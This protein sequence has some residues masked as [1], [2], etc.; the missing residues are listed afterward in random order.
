MTCHPCR[1]LFRSFLL[2]AGLLLLPVSLSLGDDL[3]PSQTLIEWDAKWRY[4]DGNQDL[5]EGWRAPDYD[6]GGWKEGPALLGYSRSSENPNWPPPGLQTRMAPGLGTYY[7]RTEFDFTGTTEHMKLR[8]DHIVDDAAVFYLNGKEIGRSRFAPEG[9]VTFSSR[10]AGKSDPA[11]ESAIFPLDAATLRQGRNVLAVSLHNRDTSSSDIAFAARLVAEDRRVEGPPVG[12]VLTWQRDPTT[13]MTVDWHRRPTELASP[14]KIQ[15]RPRGA[16]EWKAF[17]AARFDF[18]FSDRKIDRVELTGLTPDTEYEFRGGAASPAYYFRTMPSQLDRPLRFAVG[19]DT[20]HSQSWLEEMNRVAMEQDPEFVVW[21][22]DLAYANGD[23]KNLKLW[24]EWFEGNMNT[25]VTKDGR[26][27]PLVLCIG[28]HEVQGG[29]HQNRMKDDAARQQFAPFFYGL[30]AFPGQPGYG[31]LDFGN[32]L[33]IVIG[34]TDHTNPIAGKQTEWMAK[35]LKEREKFTHLIPLYHVPAY[36]S[37]RD[38]EGGTSRSVRENWLPL[39]EQHGV[40]LAFEN[41]DHTFKRSKPIRGGKVAEDGIVFM[42]DGAWGVGQRTVHDA[43][44]TWYLEKSISIR[45]GMI[46]TLTPDA[47]QVTTWSH[48]GDVIDEVKIPVR[49]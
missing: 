25:L 47:A 48:R 29:S 18:P 22:G 39:F 31:A 27:P 7:L 8:M 23:P 9:E 5:S 17:D 36:P 1:F 44:K 38:Y 10:A 45:H 37:H 35:T 28:N 33:S 26:I 42:G 41:H 14:A 13:T 11:I 15:V 2:W 6:A 49:K 46:V 3:L 34:D 40:R 20:R 43:A 30:F 24:N 21:G 19:G 12:I 16:G 4:H 32:Y